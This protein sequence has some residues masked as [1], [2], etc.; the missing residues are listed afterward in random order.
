MPSL[1]LSQELKVSLR[2]ISVLAF[3]ALL[4]ILDR[5]SILTAVNPWRIRFRRAGPRQ[6]CTE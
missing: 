4:L 3:A 1:L 5:I 2:A 6:P